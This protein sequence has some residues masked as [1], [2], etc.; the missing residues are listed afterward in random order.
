MK[1]TG[2]EAVGM[3]GRRAEDRGTGMRG[4]REVRR[5]ESE[6]ERMG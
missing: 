1:G 4:M 5:A 6:F 3:K 2:Y